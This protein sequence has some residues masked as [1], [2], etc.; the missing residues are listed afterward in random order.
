MTLVTR[1]FHHIT[2]VARDSARTVAFYRDLLG[3]ALLHRTPNVDDAASEHLF[4]TT[5]DGAPGTL[6]TVLHW[7]D[8]QH[9]RWGVG[10]I[11][12]LALG[13][14]DETAQL[15]W[16]RWLMQHD[17][18]VS[19][20]Y[21]RGWF[22]SIYFMDPDRQ[23]L[24][25]ATAG[26]GYT[27]DEPIDAL[28]RELRLPKPAQLRGNRD[29]AAIAATTYPDDVAE[30]GADMRLDGIHHITGITSEV[31]AMSE[32]YEAA[33]GLRLVKRTVN[34]DDPATAHWFWANYDGREVGA[35]SALTMFGWPHSDYYARAG[36]GQTH[37]VAFRA[38]DVEQ[39]HAWHDHLRALGYDPTPVLKR[40]YYSSIFFTAP[41]G[42]PM[43]IATDTLEGD[44]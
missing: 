31:A 43:E 41:D 21:D 2:L 38:Q 9:G 13:V 24:E 6:V 36:I 29:E 15:K 14:S 3:L 11:H 37:H 1:G 16:K 20:P 19:G 4:F 12:H 8:L 34:Q 26:P 23:V 42:L 22:K 27:L 40:A 33:L 44:A 5:A 30:I 28:G 39:L 35:H 25:I 32:F 18:A 17:V 10:G 7:S